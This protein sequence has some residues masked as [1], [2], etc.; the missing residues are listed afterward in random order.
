MT[1]GYYTTFG[2][3]IGYDISVNGNGINDFDNV[4]I[5]SLTVPGSRDQLAGECWTYIDDTGAVSG[6][7]AVDG[8]GAYTIQGTLTHVRPWG[9][10]DDPGR[11]W[12]GMAAQPYLR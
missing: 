9:S 7:F 12:P 6:P 5:S 8:S 11:P 4:A 3:R 2:I 10:N 1:D